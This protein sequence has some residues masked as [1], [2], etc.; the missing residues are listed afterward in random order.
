MAHLDAAACDYDSDACSDIVPVLDDFRLSHTVVVTG[1]LECDV[2]DNCGGIDTDDNGDHDKTYSSGRPR[3][4]S[5]GNDHNGDKHDGR[6]ERKSGDVMV[7]TPIEYKCDRGSA[8]GGK[9]SQGPTGG[10][11]EG[12]RS[13]DKEF[14]FC[15]DDDADSYS[16]SGNN[17][18]EGKDPSYDSLESD[19]T[20]D[21]D[22]REDYNDIDKTLDHRC[23]CTVGKR[24][25]HADLHD[26]LGRNIRVHRHFYRLSEDT[27]QLAKV[28]KLLFQLE[29]GNI[30]NHKGKTLEEIQ[31]DEEEEIEVDKNVTLT[32][33]RTLSRSIQTNE[34]PKTVLGSCS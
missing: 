27:T 8:E 4:V 33:A 26:F 25:D 31:I 22:G 15:D 7:H 2:T 6:V 10:G 17:D 1:H 13:N 24:N 23:I 20:D 29:S 18:D 9:N 21:S 34:L 32:V 28:S 19:S 14:A 16:Q 11:K 3:A 12:C 30:T 5:K